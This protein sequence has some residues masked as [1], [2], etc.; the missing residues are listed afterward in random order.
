[1]SDTT[2]EVKKEVEIVTEKVMAEEAKAEP[3]TEVKVSETAVEQ[4]PA[5]STEDVK[6]VE[7]EKPT[8][9][10]PV[11]KEVVK[12]EEEVAAPAPVEVPVTETVEKVVD[13]FENMTIFGNKSL[14][15]LHK[16]QSKKSHL[17]A[18]TIDL[19]VMYLAAI[20]NQCIIYLRIFLRNPV[21]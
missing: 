7:T 2:E 4:Q 8:E 14:D 19:A 13:Q 9:I 11:E 6:T 5:A 21:Y 12:V 18:G 10:S 1:M 16:I 3:V 20:S 17:S 15:E